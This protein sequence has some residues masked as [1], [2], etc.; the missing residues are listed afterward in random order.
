MGETLQHK[1]HIVQNQINDDVTTITWLR[2][3]KYLESL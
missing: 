1:E 3:K 2:K